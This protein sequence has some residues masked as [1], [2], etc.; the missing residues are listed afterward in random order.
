MF[1]LMWLSVTK[2][3]VPNILKECSASIILDGL[4]C[5]YEGAKFLHNTGNH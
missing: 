5:E 1:N 2:L 4:I 3:V